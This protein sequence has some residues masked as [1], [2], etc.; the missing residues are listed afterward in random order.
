MD[1]YGELQKLAKLRHR[2]LEAYNLSQEIGPARPKRAPGERF[3]PETP[4]EQ[5][6]T[7]LDMLIAEAIVEVEKQVWETEQLAEKRG[8]G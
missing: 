7:T 8:G 6:P 4:E 2:L 5:R 1:P 3:D